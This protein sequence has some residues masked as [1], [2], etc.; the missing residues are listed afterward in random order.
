MYNN[1]FKSK[2]GPFIR[3]NPL[4]NLAGALCLCVLFSAPSFASTKVTMWHN[5]ISLAENQDFALLISEFEKH[6]AG[7]KVEASVYPVEELKTLLIQSSIKDEMP[8]VALFSADLL[9]FS[10]MLKL[11]HVPNDWFVGQSVA[12][13][14]YFR[15][16]NQIGI[17]ITLGRFL[18]LFVNKKRY[19]TIPKTWNEIKKANQ[20]LALRYLSPYTFMPFANRF[21]VIEEQG[22][23]LSLNLESLEK[24]LVLYQQI[25]A[26]KNVLKPC[27]I[28]CLSE[29]FYQGKSAF[30][31]NGV[32]AL[33]AM[34][35]AMGDDLLI[36]PLPVI[37]GSPLIPARSSLVLVFPNNSINGEKKALLKQF[38]HY[39]Q[40]N[41]AQ[42][43]LYEKLGVLPTNREVKNKLLSSNNENIQ[44][45][46]KQL[47]STAPVP[48]T[49]EMQAV[50]TAFQK[51]LDLFLHGKLN[52]QQAAK[53]IVKT[54][55]RELRKMEKLRG[56]NERGNDGS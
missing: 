42:T 32:W 4:I 14:M 22:S 45:L 36:A 9:G 54:M 50:W 7:V 5:S 29:H 1:C 19:S 49:L 39:L 12:D 56:I 55:Q 34:Q 8:D 35:N 11:S 20:P 16:E 41:D 52:E 33:K 13:S 46:Y 48:I 27:A 53:F 47:K 38:A 2:S 40:S 15:G 21:N 51:G 30:A 24:A 31:I 43:F 6:H 28:E 17:P 44:Q 23:K 37:Q 10:D 26:D 18:M 3:A 25:I